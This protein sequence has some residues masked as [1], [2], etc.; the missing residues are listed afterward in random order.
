MKKPQIREYEMLLRLR[1]FGAAHGVTFAATSDAGFLFSELDATLDRLQT[2]I[3]GQ[4]VGRNAT[5]DGGLAKRAARTHLRASLLTLGRM[6]R[7]AAADTPKSETSFTV[8]QTHCDQRLLA[9]AR[10]F[11]QE[12]ATLRDRFVAHHLP[13]AI[14]ED[15]IAAV[16]AFK[17]AIGSHVAAK[18][19]RIAATAGIRETLARASLIAEKLDLVI[20][21]QFQG[22]PGRL[23]EWRSALHVVKVA[24][25]DASAPEPVH[26]VPPAEKAA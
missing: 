2:H 19:S 26:L 13:L 14:L 8:P 18:D 24:Q 4:A 3:V 5:R 22:D 23:A 11:V 12:A 17:T 6:A 7:I 9:G 21:K 25:S 20:G 1:T 16:E 15:G 10:A